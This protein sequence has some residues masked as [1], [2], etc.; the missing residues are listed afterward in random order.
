MTSDPQE[1]TSHLTTLAGLSPL[2]KR[3]LLGAGFSAL[4]G[5][6]TMPYLYVYLVHVRDFSTSTVGW[7]FAWMGLLG[8]LAAPAAGTLIDRFGPRLVMLVGLSVEAL[9]VASLGWISTVPQGVV[10]ASVIVLGTVGLWPAS[11]A[12]LTRLVPEEQRERVYGFNFMLLNAGLGVGGLISSLLIN[13]DSLASFQVLYLI[14]AATYL[15]F[16]GVLISLPRGTGKPPVTTGEEGIEA[17]PAEHSVEPSWGEVLADRKL[18]AFVA[19][20]ILA[21]TCGY[22]QMETGLAAYAVDVAG[23]PARSLG[24]AYGANT[25]AIVLG[26]LV[27]L[28]LIQGRRRTAVLASAGLLWTV[29]WI[30]IGLSDVASG[31]MA[32][33]AIVVGLGLFGL[34]ETLWAPVA[35]AVVNALAPERMRGRYNALQGVA[36]TVGSIIGPASAGLLIGHG[37]A[38]LW[39]SG[40][41]AGSLLGALGMWRLRTL[42]GDE[43]DGVVLS[44]GSAPGSR[45]DH[46]S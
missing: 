46:D 25:A 8:F 24:W 26:Q 40:V 18:L 11:T 17:D 14:D 36:W 31:W 15:V 13:V 2:V 43:I 32:A 37:L 44:T 3:I 45:D 6:L 34:G 27:A 10:V 21:I 35:P 19:V 38:H 28:R 4:G 41:I 39:I 20:S 42:L 7:V 23:V 22:A 16:I 30:V 5:G 1:S 12:M 33:A 29:S 9:S